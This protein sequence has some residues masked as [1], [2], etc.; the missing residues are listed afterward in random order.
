MEALIASIAT[1]G[2]LALVVLAACTYGIWTMYRDERKS[3][4]DALAKRD[5]LLASALDR[6]TEALTNLRLV[7]AEKGRT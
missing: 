6:Q 2:N 3:N 7:L 1:S 5:E 4:A